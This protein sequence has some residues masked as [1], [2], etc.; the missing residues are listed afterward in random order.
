MLAAC[1]VCLGQLDEARKIAQR[2]L[3]IEPNMHF[4]VSIGIVA[5]GLPSDAEKVATALQEAGLPE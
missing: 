1:Y 4:R 3:K 5:A 2:V